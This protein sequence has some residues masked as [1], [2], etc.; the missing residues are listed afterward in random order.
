LALLHRNE[1]F[2][3]QYKLIK[4]LLRGESN[5]PHL[6]P[7][8]SRVRKGC[9]LPLRRGRIGWGFQSNG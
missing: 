6:N 5:H 1:N 3:K 4:I 7:P 8:S 2:V 9:S